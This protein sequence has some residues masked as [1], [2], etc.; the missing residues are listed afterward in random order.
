[1]ISI[2]AGKD[3]AVNVI[4]GM[5]FIQAMK[6][7]LDFVDNVATCN[8]IDHPPFPIELRRTSNTVPT[9]VDVNTAG[10]VGDTLAQLERFDQT[11]SAWIATTPR[12]QLG[13]GPGTSALRSTTRWGPTGDISTPSA[14]A[15]SSAAASIDAISVLV[16][17]STAIPD[18]TLSNNQ[19]LNHHNEQRMVDFM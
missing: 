2:A 16:P 7:Q 4:L 11:Y 8:A 6:M 12:V 14:A 5:P 18:S 10:T 13:S 17:A 19:N 3:V 15:S 9:A 1:M